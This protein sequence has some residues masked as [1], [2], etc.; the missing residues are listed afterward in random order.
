MMSI[1][2]CAL[3]YCMRLGET[4]CPLYSNLHVLVMSVSPPY[5]DASLLCTCPTMELL[6]GLVVP[7]VSSRWDYVGLQLGVSSELLQVIEREQF[8]KMGDCCTAMLEHWLRG[9]P[10][11]GSEQRSWESVL[12]AVEVGHGTEAKGEIREG[13]REAAVQPDY[14]PSDLDDKVKEYVYICMRKAIPW[15]SSTLL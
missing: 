15:C 7:R 12:R 11:T 9:A 13:L 1:V 14:Q 3:A 2:L 8:M 6:F 10:G 4:H 5:S